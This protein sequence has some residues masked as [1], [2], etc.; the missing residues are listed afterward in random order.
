M[1]YGTS[2]NKSW[3][4]LEL[5]GDDWV[6]RPITTPRD[7]RTRPRRGSTW[8]AGTFGHNGWPTRE[9]W[10]PAVPHATRSR[11]APVEGGHVTCPQQ[12]DYQ[13]KNGAFQQRHGGSAPF[14]TSQAEA[15]SEPGPTFQPN[16]HFSSGI[17]IKFT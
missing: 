6:P 7:Q 10:L 8:H 12:H 11:G 15:H 16:Y 3:Q 14:P 2:L 4:G 17:R 5:Q 13:G 9:R 1:S